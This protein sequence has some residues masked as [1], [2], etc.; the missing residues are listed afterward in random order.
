MAEA[1]VMNAAASPTIG[2]APAPTGMEAALEQSL[3]DVGIPPRPLILERVGEEMRK[4][5]PDFRHLGELI[6]ADVSLAAGLLKTANSAYFGFRSRARD[7]DAGAGHALPE[8]LVAG[9]CRTGAAQGVSCRARDGTLL[10]C[11]GPGRPRLWLA[12]R[13]AGRAGRRAAG[14]CLYVR[15]VP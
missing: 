4:E 6:S 15:P 12:G 11:F 13:P 1:M 9:D 8:C 3:L 2:K 14:R 10:G 7:R 5:E